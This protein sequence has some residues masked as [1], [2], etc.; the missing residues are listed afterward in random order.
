NAADACGRWLLLLRG[1]RGHVPVG[2]L[3]LLVAERGCQVRGVA[4]MPGGSLSRGSC[5]P[6]SSPATPLPGGSASCTRRRVPAR[7][8]PWPYRRRGPGSRSEERR[9]G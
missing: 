8:S 7:L 1:D 5:R 4:G 6:G 3:V 9:V 2:E